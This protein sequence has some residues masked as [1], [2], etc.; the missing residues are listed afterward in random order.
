MIPLEGPTSPVFVPVGEVFRVEDESD[1][2][3]FAGGNVN[4]AEGFQLFVGSRNCGALMGDV[5]LDNF[6]AIACAGV[7]NVDRCVN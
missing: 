3:R 7:G 2:L 4:A 6:V 5:E 1:R